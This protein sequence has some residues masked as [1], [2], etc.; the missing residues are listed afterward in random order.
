MAVEGRE[1][2]GWR[3]RRRARE[4]AA[5]YAGEVAVFAVIDRDVGG[6]AGCWRVLYGI[7]MAV[8]VVAIDGGRWLWLDVKL[9]AACTRLPFVKF[10]AKPRKRQAAKQAKL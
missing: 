7:P 4:V 1:S 3:C 6:E 2:R 5:A 9:E 10:F 8:V